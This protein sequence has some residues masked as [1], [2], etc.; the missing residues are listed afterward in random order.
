MERNAYFHNLIQVNFTQ[1]ATFQDF[2]QLSIT[3]PLLT[4]LDYFEYVLH[5]PMFNQLLKLKFCLNAAVLVIDLQMSI[6]SFVEL[7]EMN[8]FCTKIVLQ[9]N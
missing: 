3:P 7:C 4:L 9:L 6:E 1:L 8:Q 5:I 2:Q